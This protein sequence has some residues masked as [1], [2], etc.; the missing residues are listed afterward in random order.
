MEKGWCSKRSQITIFIIIAIVIVGLI[1]GYFIVK[2]SSPTI[3]VN[4]LPVYNYYL[5]CVQE[6]AKTGADIMGSQGGYLELPN[7]SPGSTYA[8]FS[9]QLGFMGLAVPYWYY[10]SSNGI[11]KEQIP[12]KVQMQNQLSNYIKNEIGNCNF[13]SFK[14]SGYNISLGS[15]TVK[16]IINEDKISISLNQKIEIGY[17]DSNFV[18]NNHNTEVNSKL[19]NNYDLAKKIY[20]LESSSLFLENYTSDVLYTYA[21]VNGVVLNCSPAIWNPYDVIA[22]LKI[23]LENNLGV[24]RLPGSYYALKG[25]SNYFVAGK[26]SDLSI[27]DSQINFLYSSDW[28]SRFEI[29]PTKSNIMIASPVGT[30]AGLGALGFCYIPYK[31]VYD[32]YFPVLIQIS[33]PNDASEIFQFPMAVV[34][35]KNMPRDA[36]VSSTFENPENLCDNAN[37][38]LEIN[39]VDINLAPVEVDIEFKCFEDS[40]ALGKTKIDNSSGAA[41]LVAKVPQCINGLLTASS[42]GY[43]DSQQ[44]VSTNVPTSVDVILDREYTLNF[45]VYVDG[46]LTRDLAILTI[47]ENLE[48][49][50]SFVGSLAYPTSNEIKLSE[51]DYS[52]DLKVYGSGS[53]TL[54]ATTSTQCV[55]TAKSGLL[56]VF[57]LQDEKCF[58][59]NIPGQTLTNMLTAGGIQNQYI[60]PS[61]LEDARFFRIYTTSVSPP[62]NLDSIQL[63]I[64]SIESQN[65][66]IEII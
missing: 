47:S 22:N 26:N 8:P 49:T 58:D 56:G 11:K 42:E 62:A 54:P 17:G 38:D 51:G 14:N 9:S 35:N 52:F 53:I 21:P 41:R 30:Q 48:N 3:P 1:A 10:I 66:E 28:P 2:K 25:I 7:F 61:E 65:L 18:L 32:M 39:S 63:N 5:S 16:V 64:D 59:I 34:I 50:T 45:E 29:W 13:D 15:P 40:C 12:T 27:K 4:I 43:K 44:Y 24:I 46:V 23:A 31:F 6:N 20:T 19:G 57:G 36:V 37:T 33:N 60:T 55:E